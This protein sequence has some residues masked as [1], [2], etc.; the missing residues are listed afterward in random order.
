MQSNHL[1]GILVLLTA[2]Q[3]GCSAPGQRAAG[4]LPHYTFENG[5]DGWFAYESNAKVKTKVTQDTVE[6]KEG[7]GALKVKYEFVP[8]EY[9]S[10]V[11]A[12]KEDSMA[13]MQTI[14][15]WLKSD[16]PTAVGVVLS[17]RTPNGGAYSASFWSPENTWQR[18][19]LAPNDFALNEGPADS[20]DPNGRLDADRIQGIGIIDLG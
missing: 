1:A 13:K 11:V 9:G 10:A 7:S 17:E 15:F 3:F 20:P 14:R 2:A 6:V 8:N 16:L 12:V 5:T 18:I 19:E 4:V